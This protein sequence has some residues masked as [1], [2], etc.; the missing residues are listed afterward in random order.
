M[1]RILAV[2]FATAFLFT[3]PA[4]AQETT[5]ETNSE[6]TQSTE[7]SAAE[8][9]DYA[10]LAQQNMQNVKEITLHTAFGDMQGKYSGEMKDNLP[11]GQGK[12]VSQ[13]QNQRGWFYEGTFK[14]GH[15]EGEG[16]TVFENGQVQEGTYINDIWHPNTIQYFEFMQ[17]LPGSDFTIN[18]KARS[19][20]TDEKNYFP[21][22]S[23]E[24]L[25]S[26][27]DKNITYED[28]LSNPTQYGDKFLSVSDLTVNLYSTFS[29]TENPENLLELRGAYMETSNAQGENY[30]I[31]Y[32]GNINGLKEFSVIDS[33]IGI[34]LGVMQ[35]TDDSGVEKQYVVLAAGYVSL[36]QT[37][38]E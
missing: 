7:N 21:V 20:F 14:N 34:P 31:Y 11:H 33:A 19:V 1:K 29:I 36:E 18:E 8:S 10:V 6:T 12:F 5:S 37:P 30:A 38:I 28:I 22:S 32:R 25:Y 27:I 2:M 26:V 9:S 24:E 16:K 35:K 15:F 17:T 4:C 23:P 13:N 3:I